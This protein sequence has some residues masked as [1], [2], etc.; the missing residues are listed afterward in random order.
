MVSRLILYLGMIDVFPK[1]QEYSLIYTVITVILAIGGIIYQNKTK[2]EE[3]AKTF[4]N[5]GAAQPQPH[6][7]IY[8]PR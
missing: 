5:A 7:N 6:V 3:A 1:Y 8:I 2:P 4:Y